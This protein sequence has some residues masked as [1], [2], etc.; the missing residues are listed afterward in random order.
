[1]YIYQDRVAVSDR[2]WSMLESQQKSTE[3]KPAWKT[4]FQAGIP[5]CV[6]SHFTDAME[7]IHVMSS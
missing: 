5:V 2:A 3:K 4:D 6:V 7:D 1:M